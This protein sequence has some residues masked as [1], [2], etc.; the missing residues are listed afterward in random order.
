MYQGM[1]VATDGTLKWDDAERF[2]GTQ[3]GLINHETLDRRID[4]EIRHLTT[5]GVALE[6]ARK[7]PILPHQ[8]AYT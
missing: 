2:G 5:V 4:R 3:S 6:E 7:Y 8:Q 1:S